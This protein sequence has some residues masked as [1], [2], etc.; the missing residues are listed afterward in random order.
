M[1][2]RDE[3]A[4]AGEFV[5]LA[6]ANIAQPDASDFRRLRD[7]KDLL[8][9]GVP[10]HCDLR[11]MEQPVLQDLLG[12]QLVAPVH[13][14]D[15]PRVIGQINRLLDRRVAAADDN[16]ILV[17]EKEPVAGRAGRD[18]KA[19]ERLLAWQAEPARLRAGGDDYRV[20]EIEIARIGGRDKRPAPEIER[21]DMV[22]DDPGPDMLGLGVHLLHQPGS[23]DDVGKPR[24]VLDIGG[25]R[26]LAAGL[27]PGQQNR[28]QVGAGGID[29]RGIAGRPGADDQNLA[30]MV[31]RHP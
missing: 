29:R 27:D 13:Q 12:A 4:V 6:A 9:H 26:Q 24:V 1:A 19:A 22:E 7:A 11:V 21:L 16:H 23:L 14:G 30:V 28:L 8:D 31:L 5:N 3:H 18:A 25:D 17:A 10:Y 15:P 2:D 20:A